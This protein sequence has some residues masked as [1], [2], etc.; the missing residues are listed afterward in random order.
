MIHG[1]VP[2]E[3]A[4]YIEG[5]NDVSGCRYYPTNYDQIDDQDCCDL[6]KKMLTIDPHERA[7]AEDI[8]NHI[9]I[10]KS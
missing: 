6:L 2:P 1:D 9:W 10:T 3:N 4:E 7:T 5:T 8:M